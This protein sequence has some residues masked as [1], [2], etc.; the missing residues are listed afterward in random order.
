M[1]RRI[2]DITLPMSPAL[3]CWPGDAPFRFEWTCRKSDGAAV[4][5]GQVSMSVHTGTHIDAPFHF[6][7][8]GTTVENLSLEPFIGR[9]QVIDL[10]GRP[11]IRRHVD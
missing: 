9:A 2:F 4:N 6:S 8:D 5:V 3:A 11:T 7:N 1:T 10:R